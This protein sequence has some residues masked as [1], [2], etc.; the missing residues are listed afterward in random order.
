LRALA[1]AA[2]LLALLSCQRVPVTATPAPSGV[3]TGGTL[4]VAIPG[5]VT[6]LDPW[7]ADAPTLVALR[8]IFETLVAVDP[9]TGAVVPG[10]AASW[11]SVNNGASWTFTLREG[12]R[13]HD[14]SALDAAAVVA[15]LERGR[16]TR[17]YR[18]LFDEP[19]M[20]ERAQALDARTV[21]IDL[22][23]PFGPFLAHLAAPQAA[24]AKGSAG[25][26]PFAAAP[27]AP[28]PDGTLT[29]RRGD[30]PYWRKD[31]AG[32]TLPYLDGLVLRP[33]RDAASRLAELRAG[34]VDIVLDLPV[35]QAAAARGDPS[36]VLIARRDAALASLGIDASA[37]PFDRP[38]VRR[39]V[40]MAI[41]RNALSAVYAGLSR[42][43]V[44]LV[45]QGTLGHDDSIVEFAPF[46]TAAARRALVD[47]H[48]PTP[49][50]AELAYPMLATSA[51]PDP[52]RIA[53]SLAADLGK[54][55]IVARLRA[56]D[57]GAAGEP[58]AVLALDTTLI[59]LDPDEV[60]WPLLGPRPAEGAD[61][62]V[63]GLLRKARGEADPDKRAELY[64]QVSKINRADALR[65]PLVFADR[66]SA[67][68]ARLA[69]YTGPTVA[70]DSFGT[71]WLRP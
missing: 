6:T 65:I 5:E 31:A 41:D 42:A 24:I 1:S 17:S 21:R 35:A 50:S 62:L 9:A 19:P 26:G 3:Q 48:V 57:P 32:K 61:T 69:G 14:G 33:V 20:L 22:R 18:L 12:V 56:V 4:R 23:A 49:I 25:T 38:E 64:K 8:Q 58:R 46:D 36:L 2:L 7:T 66:A 45:P 51:Y 29:L 53:Q 16:G 54:I 13:F 55:G 15:S 71:V 59:G 68:S 60:F 52:Q 30:P 37:P 70:T 67:S 44:Q 11:Q 27:G 34:R 40:A 47:A 63:I 28:A 39:A 43:A 10:L